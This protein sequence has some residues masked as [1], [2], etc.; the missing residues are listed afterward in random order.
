MVLLVFLQPI[1]EHIFQK[2]PFYF[3]YT[4]KNNPC[5]R[6][7]MMELTCSS[8]TEASEDVV[9]SSNPVQTFSAGPTCKLLTKNAIFQSPEDDGSVFVCAGDEA[10]NSA[11]VCLASFR[12]VQGF[13]A[14]LRRG[15]LSITASV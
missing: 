13:I 6:C 10:S 1:C 11:L 5:V 2:L 14:I 9:C 4:G 15:A 12:V 3:Y 8:L 7:V